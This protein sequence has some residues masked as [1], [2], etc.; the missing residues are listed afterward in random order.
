[1]TERTWTISNILSVSRILLVIPVVFL[2]LGDRQEHR[3][4]VVGIMVLAMLTDTF[5]GVLARA[6]HQ[7]TELGRILDPLADKIAVVA[8]AGVLTYREMVPLWFFVVALLRDLLILAG[9]L[10][11][12][13]KKKIVLQPNL[14]G[15]WTVTVIAVYMVITTLRVSELQMIEQL[16]LLASTISMIASFIGYVQKFVAVQTR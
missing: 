10:Y 2:L 16:L 1:M 15:K 11:I 9:G 14:L 7:E 12:K 8:I 13:M 3:V 4:L 6:L 5:D